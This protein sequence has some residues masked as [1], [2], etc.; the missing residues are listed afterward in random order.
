MGEGPGRGSRWLS[1]RPKAQGSLGVQ[2]GRLGKRDVNTHG[3]ANLAND[4]EKNKSLREVEKR[5]SPLQAWVVWAWVSGGNGLCPLALQ[6]G[7][8]GVSC[9]VKVQVR[10]NCFLQRCRELGPWAEEG[11]G[12]LLGKGQQVE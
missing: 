2:V 1:R 12:A 7:M 11:G 10:S 5:V 9:R 4:P 8:K 3:P 6:R